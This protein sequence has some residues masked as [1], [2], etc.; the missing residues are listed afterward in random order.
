VHRDIK[1]EN[2]LLSGAS[3]GRRFRGGPRHQR[4]RRPGAHAD[5]SCGR[6]P[7]LHEPRAGHGR[8]GG[9]SQRH[10]QPG[11]CAVR[12]PGRRGAR[13]V[14]VR[15]GDRQLGGARLEPDAARGRQRRGAGREARDF[16]G[17]RPQP[18]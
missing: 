4:S 12:A 5:G 11:V 1:P 7:G 13:A 15:E 14:R 9:R 18:R 10:L 2:I 6:L 8:R 16:P 3:C 17:A